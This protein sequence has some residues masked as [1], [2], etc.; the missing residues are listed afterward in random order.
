M[1]QVKYIISLP[2]KA[3]FTPNKARCWLT[4]RGFHHKSRMIFWSRD[5]CE[6]T[7]QFKKSTIARLM[8]NKLGRVLAYYSRRLNTQTLNCHRLLVN[9]K[10]RYRWNIFSV[11]SLKTWLVQRERK[12]VLIFG[13]FLSNRPKNWD[14]L[15]S[16]FLVVTQV[17]FR[18]RLFW[19]RTLMAKMKSKFTQID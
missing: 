18:R 16:S 5:K 19:S 10:N 8:A 12:D 9:F 14:D 17:G 1:W 15:S 3:P 11:W 2:A 4:V 6:V 13:T 7:R